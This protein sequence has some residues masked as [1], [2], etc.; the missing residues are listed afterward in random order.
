VLSNF[1]WQ[2]PPGRSCLLGPNGAGK[3]TILGLAAD[4]LVPSHGLVS[5]GD[6]VARGGRGGR[7]YRRSIAWMPQ[8]TH[9][10]PGFTSREQVAYAGWLKGL[11]QA[12]AWRAAEA[13]L[14]RVDLGDRMSAAAS[15]LS[16]GQLQRLGLAQALIHDAS[17]LLLDEPAA[18][19]DPAQR[20]VFRDLLRSLPRDRV[21]LVATH[22]VDD[23]GDLFDRVA[24]L[25][26]GVIRHEGTVEAFLELAPEGAARRAEAAYATF[27]SGW[28]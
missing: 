23:L 18:G 8:R 27:V 25:V 12:E 28:E 24:V 6:L 19:L 22:Q 4:V 2:V 17:V 11:G 16:G 15:E 3:S 5:F 13:A 9:A 21:I 1:D 26:D 14:K 10:I 7:A 20:A